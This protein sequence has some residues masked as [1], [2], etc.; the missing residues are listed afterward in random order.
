MYY[1]DGLTSSALDRAIGGEVPGADQ[2]LAAADAAG[3]KI[4]DHLA[5]LLALARDTYE[6]VKSAAPGV[7]CA[8]LDNAAGAWC[9]IVQELTD[10]TVNVGGYL[11]KRVLS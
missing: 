4:R 3:I 11:G 7:I 9:S 1:P 5:D 2:A 8:D 6:Q 10:A